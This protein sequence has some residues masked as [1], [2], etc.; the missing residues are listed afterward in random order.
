MTKAEKLKLTKE[1]VADNE[2]F[3]AYLKEADYMQVGD[4]AY[5]VPLEV[6]GQEVYAK[7]SIEA[8]DT[9]TN[10]DGE[11]IPYDPFIEIDRWQADKADK[12]AR[13]EER[14]R[15]KAETLKRAEENKRKRAANIAAKKAAQ[16]ETASSTEA[17][18]AE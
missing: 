13:A 12:K 4:F 11:K 14:A 7:I 8:K 17:E 9:I 6:G 10:D 15:K 18:A 16:A 3:R 2:L 1:E 5:V